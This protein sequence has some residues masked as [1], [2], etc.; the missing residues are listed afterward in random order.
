L[1]SE[2]EMKGKPLLELPEESPAVR[3]VAGIMDRMIH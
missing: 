2:Y 1:I 3:T